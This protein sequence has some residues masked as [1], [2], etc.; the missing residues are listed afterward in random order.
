MMPASSWVGLAAE[1][2]APLY[3]I[4]PHAHLARSPQ[5]GLLITRH[6]AWVTPDM[7]LAGTLPWWYRLM[8]LPN[9]RILREKL[10][11]RRVL[12]TMLQ[13]RGVVATPN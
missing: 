12:V 6:K 13:S 1:G 3:M 11:W 8:V 9:G 4:G 2:S 7:R 10:I 5:A